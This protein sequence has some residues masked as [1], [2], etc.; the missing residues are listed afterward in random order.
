MVR[1]S[2]L[3]LMRGGTKPISNASQP[4]VR[5]SQNR[6]WFRWTI[7]PPM[8]LTRRSDALGPAPSLS[9][10]GWRHTLTILVLLLPPL[11]L[12]R[13]WLLRL[14]RA[15]RRIRMDCQGRSICARRTSSLLG[16]N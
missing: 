15:A 8:S 2:L 10:I 9:A 13:G 12:M 4:T 16:R 11:F 6:L 14:Q 3:L 7:W 5:V 1:Q